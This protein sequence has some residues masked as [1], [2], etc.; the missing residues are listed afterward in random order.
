MEELGEA[1]VAEEATAWRSR[2]PRAAV[3]PGRGGRPGRRGGGA[4]A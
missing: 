1:P 2:Q 4:S 3:G